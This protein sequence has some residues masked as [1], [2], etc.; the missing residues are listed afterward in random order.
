MNC[1]SSRR[2]IWTLLNRFA[3]PLNTLSTLGA[4]T[5]LMVVLMVVIAPE[6]GWTDPISDS[7]IFSTGP[8]CDLDVTGTVSL[9]IDDL[10]SFG[11]STRFGNAAP[12]NPADDL[13]DVGAKN[14]VY[15]SMPFLCI[16]RGGVAGGAWLERGESS[17]TTSS[18][19]RTG[20][21]MTSS[22]VYDGIEV[23]HR[24]TFECNQIQQCWTFTNLGAQVETLAITPY[25]DGDL[26]FNDS[27]SDFG[28][29]SA[30][31]PKTIYEYDEGS[32]PQAPTTQ[33][34]L[35]GNDPN[36]QYLT[37][38]EIAQYVE[39]K[40]RI[41]NTNAGCEPLRGAITNRAGNST[42][43][44]GDLVTDNSYD[45]TLA[46]RFDAGPLAAGATSPEIC[47]T[48]RWGYAL[49]CSDEDGDEICI[50]D[51]NCPSIPNPDQADSDGD[52]VGDLCDSCPNVADM[53]NDQGVALDSDGDGFGDACDLCPMVADPE[54]RDRDRDGLGD[55]CDLC[56]EVVDP[57]QIDSDG[58]GVGD[59]CD[60][61][62]QPNPDQLD[63]NGDGIGDLCCRGEDEVCNGIDDDCDERIDEGL[64]SGQERC[65]TGQ[66]GACAEGVVSCR[67]GELKCLP[68]ESP[69]EETLCDG[70][71][72]DCDGV[73]DENLRNACSLCI[74]VEREESCNGEDEDCDGV[75]DEGAL[76]EDGRQCEQGVCQSPC[77][78]SE[79]FDGG[80]CVDG[81]CQSLCDTVSCDVGEECRERDG[82][83][84]SLC[85]EVCPEGTQCNRAGE[86]VMGDCFTFGCSPGEVCGLD[87]VCGPDPCAE[88]ECPPSSFCRA[89]AC[90]PSCAL[91]SCPLNTQCVDGE[92]L[93]LP[94]WDEQRS[95]GC[96]G[97]EVCDEEG[98]CVADECGSVSCPEGYLCD[99]GMCVGDPCQGVSC[100]V[101]QECVVVEGSAQC[102][103]DEDVITDDGQEA[104]VEAGEGAGEGAGADAGEGSGEEAGDIA[105]GPMLAGTSAN[106]TGGTTSGGASMAG[107]DDGGDTTDVSEGCN[108]SVRHG[109]HPIWFLLVMYLCCIMIR[110]ARRGM[111]AL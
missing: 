52:G 85:A 69:A 29:T 26:Y 74:D 72:E 77:V 106:M 73:I 31:I 83:C 50:P 13:P 81:Y 27:L 98:E 43:S 22:Y 92:C 24:S 42:D 66:P 101:N 10:G 62:D 104:G 55:A 78:N 18:A 4:S 3:K 46:L 65:A 16:K 95:R 20:D 17:I 64:D 59:A 9:G 53:V 103:L 84:V 39:S 48:I 5:I 34:A 75:I 2:S 87:G 90:V 23:N 63:E 82:E 38:W 110:R 19:E 33:L 30:G 45:V 47:Y 67:E 15:E 102:V 14:T 108:A 93:D 32:D 80:M 60:N 12:F 96:E 94:C 99:R 86:C 56:P 54:Q 57:D 8:T 88:V 91:V 105:G 109:Q 100:P 51:D 35:F 111:S 68:T 40:N 21:V 58:D 71:D 97:G 79:C 7:T 107:G 6:K 89:G 1:V 36:D 44:D 76:C 37:N 11:S 61:C 41:S 28:G 49:A 25:I 70:Q